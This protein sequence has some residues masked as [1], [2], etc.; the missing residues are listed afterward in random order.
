MTHDI[1]N[2]A[3]LTAIDSSDD[4]AG[5]RV[6]PHNVEAEQAVLGAILVNN[7]AASR[8]SEFLLPE[9]FYEPAHQRIYDAAT[10]LIERQQL[11]TPVT[12][13]HYFEQDQTLAEVGGAQYLGRLAGAAVT[14]YEIE[15]YARVVHDLALRRSLIDISDEVRHDAVE[16][17]IDDDAESQI[18]RAE[19]RLFEL[20]ETGQNE[21][22]FQSF[23]AA[24]TEAIHMADAAYKRD[25][26][27]VGLPTGLADLDR[28]LGG[29]HR[30]DLVILAARPAM[31]K[32]SLATNIAFHVADSYKSTVDEH[33]RTKVENGA[34]VGFFALEMSA[35]QMAT[36]ILAEEAKISSEKIRRGE[37]SETQFHDIVAATQRIREAPLFI[38]DTPALSIAA[39]RTRARRLKRTQGLGLVVVDY[40]QL[41]RPSGR[42]RNDN[43]VQEISEI[44]QGLKALAKELDVPVLALSQLSRAVEQREDK[45]PQLSDLR[46]SGAIEQDAD[47]VMF[48]FRE[49]YYHE[50]KQPEP[51]T[52]EHEKWLQ[53]AEQIHNLAEV[54]IGKQ[55]HGPTG[56]IK[57][58]FHR[59]HTKFHDYDPS[60]HLP[61]AV[62]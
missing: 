21:G 62:F 24:L 30:S 22:G 25:T 40:L 36:R 46:E 12:L 8:T 5:Y 38:D 53:R 50:R 6:L 16:A 61:D 29:L 11:A 27:L 13:K 49:E 23:N 34:V 47:V 35:E 7:D 41:L 17:D 52:P 48:L 3:T 20:A 10:R 32:T 37:V 58:Q 59:E 2:A 26:L 33:G 4:D 57:L 31:G 56:T 18:E 43:R 14:V 39:L 42:S 45:R 44:T 60:D 19:H 55:R 15:H 54:I 28:I 51:D 9:H 1:S